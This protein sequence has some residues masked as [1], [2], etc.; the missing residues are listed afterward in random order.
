[1]PVANYNYSERVEARTQ[2][3]IMLASAPHEA[4]R[5]AA[6][7]KDADLAS[8][9]R[10][11]VAA[12]EADRAQAEQLAT[13]EGRLTGSKVSSDDVLARE[14]KLRRRLAAVV[15]D[16]ALTHGEQARWLQQISY[17]RYRIRSLEPDAGEAGE[18]SAD[19]R[20]LERVAREDKLARLAGAASFAKALLG[21][22]REPI[23]AELAERQ[24]DR[25]WLEALG[26]DAE[27][28][29]VAGKNV[30]LA[31]EATDREHAAVQAQS[32]RWKAVR[33]L[34]TEACDG[35]AELTAKLREC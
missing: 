35:D 1:M 20:R 7:I 10:D 11:G 8:I 17:A 34:V 31:V 24:I 14:E 5:R 21:A 25:A 23:V 28:L 9:Q 29:A 2:L 13:M 26:N 6:G 18:V 22:G 19:A 16:L 3:A 4:R 30:R 32:A 27:A 15:A 12:R 33:D